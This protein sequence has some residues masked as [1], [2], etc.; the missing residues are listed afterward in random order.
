MKNF[1]FLLQ[2]VSWH[3]DAF[4]LVNLVAIHVYGESIFADGNS[5]TR[6]YLHMLHHLRV[7]ALTQVCYLNIVTN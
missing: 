4:A 2:Y 6:D 3:Y 1:F 5:L 7:I